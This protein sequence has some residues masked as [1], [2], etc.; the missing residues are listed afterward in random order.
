MKDLAQSY[1]YYG[2]IA[3]LWRQIRDVRRAMLRN[4]AALQPLLQV[5]YWHKEHRD[6]S[7]FRMSDKRFDAL[8]QVY[9]DC[10]ETLCRLTVMVVEIE[11]IIHHSSLEIPTKKGSMTLEEFEAMPNGLKPGIIDKYPIADLFSPVIDNKLRNGI[12]HNSAHYEAKTDEMICYETKDAT[13]MTRSIPY[14]EFCDRVLGLFAAFELA[15]RYYHA[16]HVE[17]GGALK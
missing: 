16:L 6:L 14:T 9:I 1:L 5:W 15:E 2:K 4:Y 12:G 11:A 8:R 10:Y 17:V 7:R 13:T 3:A